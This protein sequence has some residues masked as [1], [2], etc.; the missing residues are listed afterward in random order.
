MIGNLLIVGLW[1]LLGDQVAGLDWV[2]RLL[3]AK[4]RVLPMALVPLDIDRRGASGSTRRPGRDHRRSA[5]RSRWRPPTARSSRSARARRSAGLP[6]AVEAIRDADWV[7][8]GPG[9]VVHLGDPAPA[10]AGAA[11]R[12]SMQHRGPADR[13]AQPGA[14]AGETAGSGRRA[15]RAA[16]RARPRPATRRRAGRQRFAATI[17][18]WRPGQTSL[19]RPARSSPTSPPRDGSPRHDPLKLAAAYAEIMSDRDPSRRSRPRVD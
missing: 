1:E 2:G 8:L 11:P 13:D 3:G 4:G 6:E 5:A 12:R 10:G 18:I 16:R 15:H 9:L 19:G 14:Q 17:R 7:V